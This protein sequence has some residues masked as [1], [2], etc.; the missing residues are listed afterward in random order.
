MPRRQAATPA[1]P[2]GT[3]SFVF[4]SC[5]LI[6]VQYFLKQESIPF[7]ISTTPTLISFHLVGNK[8]EMEQ[9]L[10]QVQ[11]KRLSTLHSFLR[12]SFPGLYCSSSWRQ[13][14][15]RPFQSAPRGWKECLMASW[16]AE[17]G[18]LRAAHASPVRP[19]VLTSW[20]RIKGEDALEEESSW[21][22]PLE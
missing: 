6:I 5:S 4:P 1:P 17:I 7:K 21:K 10:K 14:G 8:A 15:G 18:P 22:D 12:S 19:R 13:R 2:P 3:N 9:L 20:P 11:W 16:R